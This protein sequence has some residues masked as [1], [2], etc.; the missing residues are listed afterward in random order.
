MEYYFLYIKITLLGKKI[1][2]LE[3]ITS[4]LI[5]KLVQKANNYHVELNE[6]QRE[7]KVFKNE[8]VFDK[9]LVYD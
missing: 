5:S 3:K 2:I 7:V 6:L 8:Y 4:L 9:T 1:W